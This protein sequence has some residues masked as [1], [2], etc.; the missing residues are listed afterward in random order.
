MSENRTIRL[1]ELDIAQRIKGQ[2]TG[3]LS[4]YKPLVPRVGSMIEGDPIEPADL[5]EALLIATHDWAVDSSMSTKAWH[6]YCQELPLL[7]NLLVEDV[8]F[9]R[10]AIDILN[11]FNPGSNNLKKITRRDF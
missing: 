8:G 5:V 11:I 6:D 1:T 7:I 3:S 10:R 4:Q 9:A 2:D